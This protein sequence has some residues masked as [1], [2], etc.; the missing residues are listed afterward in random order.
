MTFLVAP[1]VPDT[2]SR[3][4]YERECSE[5]GQEG[6]HRG[7]ARLGPRGLARL[8]RLEIRVH[9]ETPRRPTSRVSTTRELHPGPQRLVVRRAGRSGGRPWS[10][11]GIRGVARSCSAAGDSP[12]RGSAPPGNVAGLHNSQGRERPSARLP[13]RPS[14]PTRVLSRD[15]SALVPRTRAAR[16][17]LA[18]RGP[19]PSRSG[20][21]PQGKRFPDGPRGPVLLLTTARPREKDAPLVPPSQRREEVPK[22]VPGPA[23]RPAQRPSYPDA[24]AP[25]QALVSRETSPPPSELSGNP[26]SSH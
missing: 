15:P 24:S 20:S 8:V 12:C 23:S 11:A 18:H 14:S 17:D 6:S 4:G 13:P 16:R 2:T 1:V 5:P 7:F 3:G 26:T 22:D 19:A 25:G 10:G 9:A 21:E